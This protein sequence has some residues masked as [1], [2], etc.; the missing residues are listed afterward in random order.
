[1]MQPT[2]SDKSEAVNL[3]QQLPENSTLE[4]IQYHLYVLEKIKHGRADVTAGKVLSQVE[5]EV[6]LQKWL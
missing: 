4:D 2:L 1:M 6:K 3:L 5:L